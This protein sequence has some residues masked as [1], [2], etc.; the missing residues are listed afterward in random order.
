MHKKVEVDP[1]R[2]LRIFRNDAVHHIRK[3]ATEF[4]EKVQEEVE[5][6]ISKVGAAQKEKI[7]EQQRH[8]EE[9]KAKYQASFPAE[10]RD[11][12]SAKENDISKLKAK[13]Q[14]S[15]PAKLRNM[16]S[17]KEN[18]ISKLKAFKSSLKEY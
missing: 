12:I 14:E 16:I 18:D 8:L 17:A 5:S 15:F 10:L 4:K 6:Y 13:Y 7:D 11:M 2:A 1:E 3:A 9:L